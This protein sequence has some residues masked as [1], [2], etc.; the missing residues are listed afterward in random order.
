MSMTGPAPGDVPSHPALAVHAYGLSVMLVRRSVV[1]APHWFAG[2]KS[3]D[4]GDGKQ[5]RAHEQRPLGSR[6]VGFPAQKHDDESNGDRSKGYL[7]EETGYPAKAVHHALGHYNSI[8]LSG[9]VRPVP[10][11]SVGLG[12]GPRWV[13]LS[14]SLCLPCRACSFVLR[15]EGGASL[16]CDSFFW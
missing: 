4:H 13:Q 2:S 9:G 16:P 10:G 6:F 3:S 12:A 11:P 1:F 7:E 5:N 15:A 14:F 8:R